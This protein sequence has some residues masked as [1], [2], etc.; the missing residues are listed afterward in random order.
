MFNTKILIILTLL[1]NL[2]TEKEIK[3]NWIEIN[4]KKYPSTILY[5]G[6][7]KKFEDT[8]ELNLIL[9][10]ENN[11]SLIPNK[12]TEKFGINCDEKRDCNIK[13]NKLIKSDFFSYKEANGFFRFEKIDELEN[14]EKGLDFKLGQNFTKNYKF[15]ENG[16]VSLLPNSDFIKYLLKSYNLKN[17]L[18]DFKKKDDFFNLHINY[19]EKNSFVKSEHLSRSSDQWLIKCKLKQESVSE[20]CFIDFFGQFLIAYCGGNDFC[21]TQINKI[22]IGKKNCKENEADLSKGEKL[23]F[24]IDNVLYKFFAK[25]YIKFEKDQIICLVK[26]KNKFDY[27]LGIYFF[28]KFT[29]VIS[30]D[31]E[32]VKILFLDYFYIDLH[33]KLW[34]SIIIALCLLIVIVSFIIYF[35][36]RKRRRLMKSD[37][38]LI[39]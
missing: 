11:L 9:N 17:F 36:V 34:L 23:E 29:P 38:F 7:T 13:N 19:D 30:F 4:E 10:F 15:A 35:V 39:P 37:S 2:R 33:N 22:C 20:D 16:L 26:E 14:K 18:F 31:E 1:N 8:Q 12:E 25:D 27:S 24:Y 6:T 3:I 21:E 5:T 32:N 28:Q